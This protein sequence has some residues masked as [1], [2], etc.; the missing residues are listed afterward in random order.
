[1]KYLIICLTI[2]FS[3]SV[4]AGGEWKEV[5]SDRKDNK[6]NVIKGKDGK[7]VQQCKKIKV[8]KKVEGTKI[9]QKK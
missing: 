7:P 2:L 8:H 4:F 1:M 3:S 6:G 5:C 9:P